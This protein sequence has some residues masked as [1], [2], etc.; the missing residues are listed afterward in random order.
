MIALRPS[1]RLLRSL[2]RMTNSVQAKK[3]RHPEQRPKG[4]RVEGRM[5]LLLA[6]LLIAPPAHAQDAATAAALR[7]K[8]L[9][10]PTAWRLVSSLS[11]DVGARPT[12]TPQM[13]RAK[14]WAVRQ[15]T[16]L[17]FANIR[18]E[19]F[20][21]TV[22]FRGPE[23]AELV[24]GRRKLAIV[25]LGRS[26]A[27][28]VEGEVAT[29]GT[30]ADLLAQPEGSLAGKI[31]LVNQPMARTQDGSGYGALTA[32]RRQ[33][34]VEAAKRGAVGY[35]VRSLATGDPSLPHTGAAVTSLEP[36]PTIPSAAIAA[37]DAD[38]V[39]S[40]ATKGAVR[41]HLSLQ[42]RA[43]EN[44]TAWNISG[45]ITGS[46]RPE[47][48]V[49]IGAHLDSWDLGEGAVD[50]AA[51][52][53][54][55]TAAARLIGGLPRHPR[56]TI[57]VV[58]FGS[59][60]SGGSAAAYANAH[61]GEAIVAAS[62]SDFG[63]DRIYAWRAPPGSLEHPIIKTAANVLAPLAI[64]TET[65]PA[66]SAGEDVSGLVEAG[67][68]VFSLRQDGY[69]YFD[70]HHSAADTLDKVDRAQLNQNVAAWAALVYL[71]ADSDIDFRQLK[72]AAQ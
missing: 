8:A 69:R 37:T 51:G 53:A 17:G 72:A 28:P 59:E 13:A 66:T 2:L 5:A 36:W 10:D 58:M 23:F 26:A 29:F 43:I 49:L 31:V 18:V 6:C 63:A 30:Y 62:E 16:D 32:A 67:V 33:G 55:T 38:L 50:D 25:G 65:T 35:L 64:F 60:E 48:V 9:T 54:I 21:K 52:I 40:L 20:T 7:D 44:V 71:I 3:L 57:R 14:D 41:L 61:K 12:G 11:K 47:E 56:R 24:A 70:L 45:E 4:A 46:E 1:T 39:A 68:P 42:S 15:L 22:W 27:G 34:P 19:P